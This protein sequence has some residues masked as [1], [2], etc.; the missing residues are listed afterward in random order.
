MEAGIGFTHG[1][2]KEESPASIDI[3][4]PVGYPFAENYSC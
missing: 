1:I 4:T 3:S 2:E